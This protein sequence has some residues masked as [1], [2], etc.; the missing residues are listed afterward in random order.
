MPWGLSLATNPCPG[1]HPEP[2]WLHCGL[3][4]SGVVGKSG[5]ATMPVTYAFLYLSTAMP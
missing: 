1:K 3:K 5:P 4:L 2:I